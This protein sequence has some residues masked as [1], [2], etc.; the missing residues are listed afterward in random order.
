VK[1]FVDSGLEDFSIS[2]EGKTFGIQ[3]PFDSSSVSYV[4]FDALLNYVTVCQ[5]DEFWTE[6][7]EEKVHVL[8]KDILRFHAIYRPAILKSA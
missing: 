4:W 6:D 2:R 7:T 5:Q 8:G 3:L 1:A